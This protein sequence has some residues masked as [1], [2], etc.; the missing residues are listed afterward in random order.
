MLVFLFLDA[1]DLTQ[2]YFEFFYFFLDSACQADESDNSDDA[3][4]ATEEF[5]DSQAMIEELEKTKALLHA[6]QAELE[7]Q[8]QKNYYLG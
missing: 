7:D 2:Q 3:P 6:T 5:T 1:P 4:S 8:E